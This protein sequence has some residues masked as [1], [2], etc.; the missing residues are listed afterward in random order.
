VWCSQNATSGWAWMWC[1]TRTIQSRAPQKRLLITCRGRGNNK[2]EEERSHSFSNSVTTATIRS[3]PYLIS[4]MRAPPGL[5]FL[6]CSLI[7]VST[8][9]EEI[10]CANSP[11]PVMWNN[12][13]MTGNDGLPLQL[14]WLGGWRRSNTVKPSCFEGKETRIWGEMLESRH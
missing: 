1:H 10:V 14:R 8:S 4:P 12:V 9:P 2:E 7:N 5:L 13:T 6:N 11:K 3:P